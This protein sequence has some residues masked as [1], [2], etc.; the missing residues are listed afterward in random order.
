MVETGDGGDTIAVQGIGVH[1]DLVGNGSFS[2]G[3][4]TAVTV[5]S[6]GRLDGIAAALRID[7]P[8][9]FDDIT[10]DDSADQAMGTATLGT[11]PIPFD[12]PGATSPA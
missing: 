6:G 9:Y 8:N 1:T 12:T 5:G 4:V 2:V 11:L 10:V 3:K 7:N